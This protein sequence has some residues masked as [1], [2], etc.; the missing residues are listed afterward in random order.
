MLD[1]SEFDPIK[2]KMILSGEKKLC[3]FD[4]DQTLMHPYLDDSEKGEQKI[5][6]EFEDGKYCEIGFNL[7]PYFHEVLTKLKDLMVCIVFTAS[8]KIYADIVINHIDPK[9]EY[10]THRLYRN[11]CIKIEKTDLEF[12]FYVKDLR[13]F[14]SL[15]INL[16]DIILI[17]NSILSFSYQINNGIPI[18]SYYDNKEDRE[19]LYLLKH[20]TYLANA[21]DIRIEIQNLFRLHE[22][23]KPSQLKK[24]YPSDDDE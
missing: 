18:L 17:D 4:L 13:I 2:L 16:K 24:M 9:N 11:K 8:E 7:R 1:P 22:C 6:K 12:P 14:T 15:N 3:V 21:Y 5:R 10:F 20:L 19:L 23:I